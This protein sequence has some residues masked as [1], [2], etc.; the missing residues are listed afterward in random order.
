MEKGHI[1]LL[2]AGQTETVL[3][4]NMVSKEHL[5][6]CQ[7]SETGGFRVKRRTRK[8]FVLFQKFFHHQFAFLSRSC[9]SIQFIQSLLSF[10]SAVASFCAFK[11]SS[12][13]FVLQSDIGS[14]FLS[15]RRS[16]QMVATRQY[17]SCMYCVCIVYVCV[18]TTCM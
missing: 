15:V 8:T 3:N 7:K 10:A 16:F 9:A 5:S 17:V 4:D 12:L 2:Q 1:L 11:I 18:C 6:F 13:V 14:N